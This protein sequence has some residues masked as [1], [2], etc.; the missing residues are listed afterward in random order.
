MKKTLLATAIAGAIA[1]TGMMATNA[2]AANV[3]DQDGTTL[4]LYGRVAMGVTT[5][6]QDAEDG[7]K[8]TGS[9][10]V[11]IFSR[12]GFS[13]SNQIDNDLRA[14]ANLEFRPGDDFTAATETGLTTRNAFVGLE[15]AQF[16]TV[17]VGNFDGIYY[18]AVSSVFDTHPY[19]GLQ[20][21]GGSFQARGDSLAYRTPN[22]EGFQ[23]HLQAKHYT[24]NADAE[25]VEARDDNSSQVNVQAAVTYEIDALRL[26]LG[27]SEDIERG[28]GEE[29]PGNNR[30]G[31]SA[32][33]GFTNTLSARAIYET[34][35]NNEDV[36][37]LGLTFAEGPV[38]VHADLYHF[39]AQGDFKDL[40]NSNDQSTTRDG[41]SLSGIYAF[42]SSFDVFTEVTDQDRPTIDA[43]LRLGDLTD[44]VIWT[45]GVRYHF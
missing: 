15:S 3:Y 12:F 35:S 23:A 8:T 26:G 14:F 33:Y 11:D 29:Y 27:F 4:D 41:W 19:L 44:D 43:D 25:V 40:R 2:Q 9:E 45:T 34:Q 37:G 36:Y 17:T 24:G 28:S 6:G 31:G 18:Q 16:G 10:I 38:T 13:A 30:Y 32:V 21:T 1:A 39:R 7:S 22:L 20:A 42:S 5:G